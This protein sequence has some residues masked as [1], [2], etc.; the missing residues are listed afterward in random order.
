M[1][2]SIITKYLTVA[3]WCSVFAGLV[4]VNT[5][6]FA[7]SPGETTSEVH[8]RHMRVINT[9]KQQIQDDIDAVLLLNKPS[10][11]TEKPTR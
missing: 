9:Q 11:L 3:L 6:C 10:R 7:G 5:G 4:A 2:N 8:R 1:K